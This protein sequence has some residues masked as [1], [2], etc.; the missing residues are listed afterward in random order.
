MT[1]RADL[2]AVAAWL[3]VIVF[4]GCAVVLHLL[5]PGLDPLREA[6]S[7]YVHGRSGW[8]LTAGLLALAAGSAALLAECALAA[9]GA[10]GR[11]GSLLLGIW[12]LGVAIGGVFPADP[13]GHWDRPPSTAGALHGL[14]AMAALT[15]L[16]IG[17]WISSRRLRPRLTPRAGGWLVGLSYLQAASYLIFSASLA[18]VFV[19]SGPPWLMGLTERL[20]LAA[21]CLWIGAAAS[22][23]A[24]IARPLA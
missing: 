23:V 12:T 14:A 10:V 2:L 8:L 7:Y 11:T 15:A 9:P 24:R 13:P 18:P 6:V 1:R 22:C 19:T 4:L 3:G 21:A 5:Q 20:L 17:A 16:P